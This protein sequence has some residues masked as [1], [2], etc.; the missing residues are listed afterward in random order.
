MIT[1]FGA[2]IYAVMAAAVVG[3]L[4]A[5]LYERRLNNGAH[6]ENE[7]LLR[8]MWTKD[9]ELQRLRTELARLQGI[10]Q[11]RECD[12]MQRRFLETLQSEGQATTNLSR[13]RSG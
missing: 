3:L 6:S 8:Q 9:T 13:R 5:Y 1:V 2:I 10:S 11:G 4:V 7:D 12:S